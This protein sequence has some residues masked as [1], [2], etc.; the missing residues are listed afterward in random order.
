[1]SEAQIIFCDGHEYLVVWRLSLQG[2]LI[3]DEVVNAAGIYF[4][5]VEVPEIT[6]Q[7]SRRV[8]LPRRK[9]SA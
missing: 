6:L 7:L 2:C 1:M 4:D 8:Q 3:I 9:I 5:S